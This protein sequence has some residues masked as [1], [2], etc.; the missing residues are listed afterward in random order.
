[1]IRLQNITKSFGKHEVLKGI[2]LTVNKGEVVVILGPSGS[3]KTTLLRCINY[4]E[5]P[6]DGEV[7]IGDF[8][9]NC[10][11]PAKKDVLALRKKTAMVFQ[12]YHLFKH[13]TALENVM[14]GLIVVRKVKQEEAKKISIEVLEKVGLGEKLNHYPSQLSGGQQQRV[15]IARALALNP[16][17]ILFDEPT[18]ALDPE[19]VGE[20]LSV[21]RKIAKEG[22]TM[23]VV[24]H[25]MGFARDVSNHV[26]FM[27]GGHIIEEGTPDAIFNHPKEERTQQFLKRITPEYNYSI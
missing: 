22:I 15:G 7:S 10:K 19:L 12:Q 1:M 11:R 20:V 24:T 13:K 8:T 9:V 18:S 2:D 14:E 26:V 27:D 5:K 16:E 25:E 4:L 21:I 6:N 17:V 3:G 23:I